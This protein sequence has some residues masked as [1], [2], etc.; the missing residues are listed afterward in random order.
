M[1][2]STGNYAT[3]HSVQFNESSRVTNF[4]L[5]GVT[6]TYIEGELNHYR[7]YDYC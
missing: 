6:N 7:D 1:V 5:H 4:L 2:I 3:K